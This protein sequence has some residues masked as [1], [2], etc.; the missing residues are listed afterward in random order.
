MND[1]GEIKA[2]EKRIIE[3]VAAIQALV[4]EYGLARQVIDFDS[5]RRKNL[6]ATF[7]RACVEG[8]AASMTAAESM[9]RSD[10]GYADGL[11]ALGRELKAAYE[12]QAKWQALMARL[13]AARSLL[14]VSRETLRQM[15]EATGT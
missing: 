15:P 9:A 11:A 1:H 5:D 12:V 14:A 10:S 8:G 3:T 7:V 6:L 2:I 13:D 4:P